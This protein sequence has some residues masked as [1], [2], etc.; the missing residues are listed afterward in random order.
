MAYG[1]ADALAPIL[2]ALTRRRERRIGP[3]GRGMV[4][5]Q[6]IA[7]RDDWCPTGS[8]K[9]MRRWAQH[10][11]Y[12]FV[13]FCRMPRITAANLH[14]HVDTKEVETLRA[15]HAEGRGVI[16]A[17]GH[18]GIWEL[19]GHVTA[20]SGLPTVAVSRPAKNPAL[21]AGLAKMRTAGGQRLLTK[22]GVLFPLHKAL[23]RGEMI[24]I[25]ADENAATQSTFAPFL[26]TLAA[27]STT[28]AL[29]ARR[30]G[31]PIAV[32]TCNRVG[33][34]RYRLHVWDVIRVPKSRGSDPAPAGPAD[35]E[36]AHRLNAAL[37][38]A[39]AAYPE[40]WLWGSRRF[41]TRP[42]GEAA[43]P[44]G[45]PP[46]HAEWNG[47]LASAASPAAQPAAHQP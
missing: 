19:G 43:G 17:S 34:G 26:G 13:D 7:C 10:M 27:T 1:I 14:A 2:V 37:S 47:S 33:R 8:R 3:L 24:G 46:A 21:A 5:N 23:S 38:R 32:V 45:L 40:Q 11:T 25:A 29:L 6:Q 44:D 16:C 4:R 22:W 35:D 30:A 41:A 15:L 20:L 9:H 31:A 18:I 39:I 12:A 28:P 42:D 36:I